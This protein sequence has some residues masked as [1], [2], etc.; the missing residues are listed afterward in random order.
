MTCTHDLA[1]QETACADGKC[2]LCLAA[3]LAITADALQWTGQPVPASEWQK[4]VAERDLLRKRLAWCTCGVRDAA[5]LAAT[6]SSFDPRAAAEKLRSAIVDEA[7]RLYA[8]NQLLRSHVLELLAAIDGLEGHPVMY[9]I[10]LRLSA[11]AKAAKAFLVNG[12]P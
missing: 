3:A 2:P 7:P 8:D 9:S 12:A 4:L 6:E 5:A 11:A 1:E 10:A